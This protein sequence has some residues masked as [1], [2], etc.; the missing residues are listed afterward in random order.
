MHFGALI[1]ISAFKIQNSNIFRVPIPV[2]VFG[3]YEKS[4]FRYANL[5][6]ADIRPKSALL[7]IDLKEL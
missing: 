5:V 6:S 7:A 3:G 2:K 4:P 1:T